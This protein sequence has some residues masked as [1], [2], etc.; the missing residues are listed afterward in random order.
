M[1][2]ITESQPNM[3]NEGLRGRAVNQVERANFMQ[4]SVLK[5]VD[6][7]AVYVGDWCWGASSLLLYLHE[8][9]PGLL[10]QILQGY[11]CCNEGITMN[12]EK[13]YLVSDSEAIGYMFRK[14]IGVDPLRAN[15]IPNPIQRGQRVT[16]HIK[17]VYKEKRDFLLDISKEKCEER[18]L[19]EIMTPNSTI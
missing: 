9:T 6:L 15:T 4:L 17:K 11:V 5:L 7:V 2:E 3:L 8:K 16:N 18:P 10:L 14:E 1:R 12:A 19:E 13:H